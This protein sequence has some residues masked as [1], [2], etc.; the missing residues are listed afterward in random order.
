MLYL[1]RRATAPAL[2]HTGGLCRRQLPA[3]QHSA[4]TRTAASEPD[5]QPGSCGS[6][7]HQP[8]RRRRNTRF[9]QAEKAPTKRRHKRTVR[10][11]RMRPRLITKHEG[12]KKQNRSST[13]GL[14]PRQA[15]Q[16]HRRLHHTVPVT[17]ESPGASEDKTLVSLVHRARYL[18]PQE[19]ICPDSCF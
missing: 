4:E 10:L 11:L 18:F 17:A 12:D 8:A 6:S 9:P 13:S 19:T 5:L 3:L 1:K 16:G 15:P 14:Q 7:S 2:R